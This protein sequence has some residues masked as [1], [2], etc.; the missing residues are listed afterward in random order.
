MKRYSNLIPQI[1]TLDNLYLAF[2]KAR[3]G[4]EAKAEVVRYRDHL[5]Q[6]LLL[7]REEIL[8]GKCSAGDYRLFVI[9]DPKERLICAAPFS[10]RVLHHA[11]MNIC[12][13]LLDKR[14]IFDSYASRI[15]KGTYA[16]LDRAKAMFGKYGWCVKMDIRKFFDSIDHVTLKRQLAR[17]FK[18]E[19]LLRIFYDIIDSHEAA[20][21]GVAKGLPI[22]NLTSQYFANHYL[23]ELDRIA[24][25]KLGVLSYVRYMDDI[26]IFGD[27]RDKVLEQAKMMRA[28]LKD[29]LQLSL[30]LLEIRP[31]D[32]LTPFLGY[33]LAKNRML[34]GHRS[35]KRFK[36][37]L[38][39]YLFNYH[40]DKWGE[41]EM[42]Q[43][44]EPLLA[45]TLKADSLSFRRKVM[46]KVKII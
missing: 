10:Q 22:G 21:T 1:A 11:L 25:E 39:Q 40:T 38:N 15:G 46:S 24:K 7:L 19:R 30:K 3:K 28:F 17:V 23:A 36:Q 4:K 45:Y 41:H 43:H 29:E 20:T 33:R 44:I 27:D 32:K 26:L 5:D 34:L 8:S 12:G 35:M 2:W 6:N 13:P 31:A 42:L 18:E 37:K 16:A 14:Q 9:K